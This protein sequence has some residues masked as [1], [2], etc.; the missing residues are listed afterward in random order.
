[1]GGKSVIWIG[2]SW[3]RKIS[4]GRKDCK[5]EMN[6]LGLK[7]KDF[8]FMNCLYERRISAINW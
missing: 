7:D 1:M 5:K 8:S 6:E 2:G 4:L 3:L